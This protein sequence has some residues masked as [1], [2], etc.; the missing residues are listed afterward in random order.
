MCPSMIARFFSNEILIATAAHSPLRSSIDAR[1][2]Q[3][4]DRSS[5]SRVMIGLDR[6]SIVWL[7][8]REPLGQLLIWLTFHFRP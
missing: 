1:S 8:R 4:K 3:H 6:D 7:L 2:S 5:R